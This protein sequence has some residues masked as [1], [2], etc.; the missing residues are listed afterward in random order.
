MYIMPAH[1]TT[2]IICIYQYIM[3]VCVGH[4]LA[5]LPHL[6][7]LLIERLDY[8]AAYI[9]MYICL[10]RHFWL[11]LKWAS[12]NLQNA[13]GGTPA[14]LKRPSVRPYNCD[15]RPPAPSLPELLLALHHLPLRRP[16]QRRHVLR[17]PFG[18]GTQRRRA[19]L[20]QTQHLPKRN[21]GWSREGGLGGGGWGMREN[22]PKLNHLNPFTISF[23][24]IGSFSNPLLGCWEQVQGRG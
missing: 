22:H 21:G 13:A 2:Y 1:E 3:G 5:P 7:V 20:Q 9:S 14:D 16:R 18:Q 12:E 8:A 11:R 10:D 23:Q 24:G 17:R 4:L 19:E 6:P 15:P